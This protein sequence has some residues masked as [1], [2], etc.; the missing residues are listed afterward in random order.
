MRT[1][2]KVI[3]SFVLLHMERNTAVQ[4]SL[5]S[6]KSN[7]QSLGHIVLFSRRKKKKIEE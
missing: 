7:I 2:H 3:H 5:S 4:N 1:H 6:L